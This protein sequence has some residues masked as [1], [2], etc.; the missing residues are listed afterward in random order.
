MG[1]IVQLVLTAGA[2]WLSTVMVDGIE[3]TGSS[4]FN[5]LLTLLVVALIFGLVNALIKPLVQLFGCAFYVLTLGLFALV[6]NALMFWLT[7]WLA[8]TINLPFHVNG[9]WAA[10]WGA[11]IVS[12][13]S[14]F[15]GILI[16]R[17]DAD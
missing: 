14:F 4:G 6:V 8:D 7:G 10:F 5:N 9:F 16:P 3:V 1:F 13:V 17:K 15:I 12:I 2:L 11:I